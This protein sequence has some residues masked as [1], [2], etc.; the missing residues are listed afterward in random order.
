MKLRQPKWKTVEYSRTQIIRAGKTIKK[1][2]FRDEQEREETRKIIDNW[3][4]A[5]AFPL[6]IIYTHLRR[7]AKGNNNIIVAERLKRMNSIISKLKREPNM[8]LWTMQDLGGCRIIVPSIDDVYKYSKIYETS[9][10][11]HHRK[12]IYDY[13]ETPKESG[14]RSYHVVYEYH[15]DSNDAYNNNMLI[16]LQFRTQL[17]H[18]WATAVETMGLLT[19]QSLKSCQGSDDVKRFFA[20]VSSLF[21]I[22]EKTTTVPCTPNNPVKII[23]EIMELNVKNNYLA[24][25][26]G[27]KEIVA[28][29]QN[30][31]SRKSTYF[32]LLLNYVSRKLSVFTFKSSEFEE[33][34]QKYNELEEQKWC[35][36]LDVVLVRVSKFSDLRKAYPNYFNDITTFTNI[37]RSYI[38]GDT[39]P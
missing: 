10:K 13:M 29:E 6:H 20:L 34:N 33:A 15:S 16:E 26:D 8:S 1:D 5:H 17:Q 18:L 19:N 32:V 37:V 30:K 22:K 21:A 31:L 36:N 23:Q 3:R 39:I 2:L 12:K 28:Y 9:R 25:L 38:N 35:G 4:A 7:F 11:R 24:Q 27:I 14:Y